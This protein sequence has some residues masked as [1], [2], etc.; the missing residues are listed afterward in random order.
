MVG[1]GG[2]AEALTAWQWPD[3]DRFPSNAVGMLPK[4]LAADH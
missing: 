3:G 4:H 1:V 2:T